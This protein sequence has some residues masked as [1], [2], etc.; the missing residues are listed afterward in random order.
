MQKVCLIVF[1]L[2]SQKALLLGVQGFVGTGSS[3]Q[4]GTFGRPGTSRIAASSFDIDSDGEAEQYVGEKN[5][6]P[7]REIGV[8]YANGV[9]G[10]GRYHDLVVDLGLEGKL[11]QIGSLPSKRKVSPFDVFCNRE[12]KQSQLAAVGFDM[13]YTLCQ[14]K[15]P[16]F[17]KLAFDGAKEKLVYKLGYPKEVLEFEYD[18][19]V[20]FIRVLTER[21]LHG[22]WKEGFSCWRCSH[23][24]ALDER[25]DHRQ[26][27]GKFFE[28]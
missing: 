6:D 7:V 9:S 14:Y 16:A 11:K 23:V 3:P 4:P 18:H 13:D 26:G 25:L 12:L 22:G 28:D 10:Y 5:V 27:Q 21:T 20:I 15:Q 19:E 1:S 2:L 24:A 8:G 17:D